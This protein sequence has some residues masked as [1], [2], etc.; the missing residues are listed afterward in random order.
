MGPR[1][2]EDD[3]WRLLTLPVDCEAPSGGCRILKLCLLAFGPSASFRN[4][5][6][7]HVKQRAGLIDWREAEGRETSDQPRSPKGDSVAAIL[8]RRRGANSPHQ[9]HGYGRQP[10]SSAAA[11][12]PCSDLF[13]NRRGVEPTRPAF[14]ARTPPPWSPE[15]SRRQCFLAA[16]F[17]V[18][19]KWR[20]ARVVQY[21]FRLRVTNP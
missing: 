20:R 16:E 15:V 12:C 21:R 4:A 17:I 18:T 11:H 10:R 14:D 5:P 1:F 13:R 3:K 9:L 19:G 8:R 2:R 7:F 6:L